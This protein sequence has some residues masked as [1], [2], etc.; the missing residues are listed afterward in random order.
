VALG[1]LGAWWRADATK[2][3]L[4]TTKVSS[5]ATFGGPAKPASQSTDNLR[6]VWQ[7]DHGD[8]APAISFDNTVTANRLEY[9]AFA[10]LGNGDFTAIWLF[11]KTSG[12]G[13]MWSQGNS[14][15][16]DTRL[17]LGALGASSYS[18]IITDTGVTIEPNQA[19]WTDATWHI[20]TPSS[21]APPAIARI[22]APMPVT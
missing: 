1:D 5:I 19:G 12:N 15:D 14:A 4:A 3:T 6:P 22:A 20:L 17:W 11:K 2:V 21:A 13:I 9:S 16:A 10:G 18:Q 8:G 7:A